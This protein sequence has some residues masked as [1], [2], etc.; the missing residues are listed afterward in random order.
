M[1]LLLVP[2]LAC[3]LLPLTAA[4]RAPSEGAHVRCD[5]DVGAGDR[6]VRE[7]DLIVQA[8][9]VVN[10]AI[11]LH[12][13]VI[14]RKGAVVHGSAIALEGSVRLE[15]GAQVAK[16]ALAFSGKVQL[17]PS[18][19]VAGSTVAV[20]REGTLELVGEDGDG[21][22]LTFSGDPGG[23]GRKVLD[24]VLAGVHACRIDAASR[25]SR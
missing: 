25:A 1:R 3:S 10:D 20:S 4:A 21:L 17:A 23:L 9:E 19:H 24:E 16:S 6:L 5:V 15:D 2:F 7:G 22:T 12:G 14:V 13:D 11:A 8:G 18:A